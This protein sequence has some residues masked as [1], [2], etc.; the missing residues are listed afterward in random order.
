MK[1]WITRKTKI[2][3]QN[4]EI[5]A[6]SLHPGQAVTVEAQSALD[7]AYEAV[8]ITVEPPKQ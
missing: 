2:F 8:R 7:G 5:K 4:K 1:F 3:S 6:A